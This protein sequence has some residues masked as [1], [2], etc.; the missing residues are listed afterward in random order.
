MGV[1]TNG[2]YTFGNKTKPEILQ[3]TTAKNLSGTSSMSISSNVINGV[4]TSF[5]TEVF[6]GDVVRF[7]TSG[8]SFIIA[9]ITSNISMTTT[10]VAPVA[11]ASQTLA[12]ANPK[13]IKFGAS[14][15]NLT[16]RYPMYYSGDGTGITSNTWIK[17]EFCN[18]QICPIK[19]ASNNLTIT[20]GV[21]LQN[22][23]T[24]N[25]SIQAY[26]SGLDPAIAVCYYLAYGGSCVPIAVCGIHN[27]D[28]SGAITKGNFTQP[29]AST[30]AVVDDGATSTADNCGIAV[31]SSGTPVVGEVEMLV[32]FIERL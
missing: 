17:G 18:G 15:F 23:T 4:G 19:N 13:R 20:E 14:V 24:I 27:T 10:A 2:Q 9:S 5:L 7:A 28:A 31:T 22:S 1:L 16:D 8:Y 21:V 29:S 11:I 3:L 30:S 26:T 12:L 25:G 6:V 32:N